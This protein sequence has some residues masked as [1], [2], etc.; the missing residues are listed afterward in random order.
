MFYTNYKVKPEIKQSIAYAIAI[1]IVISAVLF[2]IP[3]ELFD[4]EIIHQVGATQVTEPHSLSLSY[5]VGIGHSEE[6]METIIDFHLTTSGM[7]TAVI[8]IFGI[9]AL[10]G[11][12]VYLQKTKE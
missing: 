4:G 3:I 6:N 5:F 2:L 10:I 1:S 11:Y 12:R 9:P 7:V 8:F